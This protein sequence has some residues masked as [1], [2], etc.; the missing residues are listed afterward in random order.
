MCGLCDAHAHTIRL[1]TF[2]CAYIL[3][4]TFSICCVVVAFVVIVVIVVG[5]CGENSLQLRTMVA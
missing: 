1:T 2:L 4:G 3:R 5:I